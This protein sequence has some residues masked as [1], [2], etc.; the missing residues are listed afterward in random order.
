[1]IT[2]AQAPAV[3]FIMDVTGKEGNGE[4]VLVLVAA[5]VGRGVETNN[6]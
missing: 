4:D 6:N 2:Q 1:M 3:T 5:V